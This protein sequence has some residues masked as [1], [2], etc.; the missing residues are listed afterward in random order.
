MSDLLR[1]L[2]GT[3][4]LVVLFALLGVAASLAPSVAAWDTN[5]SAGWE[6]LYIGG[7]VELDPPNE[8]SY[9]SVLAARQLGIEHLLG[10]TG[11]AVIKVVDLNATLFRPSLRGM[12]RPGDDPKTPL[13]ERNVPT[14]TH[15]AGLPDYS[16][17][18]YDWINKNSICPVLPA[19][20]TN[21]E[22]CHVFAGWMGAFN[23]NHFGSQS[24]AMYQRYHAIALGLARRAARV[25]QAVAASGVAEELASHDSALR[26]MEIE[27]L[28]F[29]NIG[30]H[31]LQ[32]RWAVGHMW[33][34]W[35]GADFSQMSRSF[36]MNFLVG[37]L[38]GLVHGSESVT[39]PYATL[40]DTIVGPSTALHLLAQDPLSSPAKRPD[41]FK[42]QGIEPARWTDAVGAADPQRGVGDWRLGD[43]LSGSYAGFPLDVQAQ[44]TRMLDCVAAGM[45]DVI[46]AFGPGPSGAGFGQH[47]FTLPAR[48]PALGEH[49][50]DAWA[51]DDAIEKALFSDDWVRWATTEIADD[52]KLA[53]AVNMAPDFTVMDLDI[54]FQEVYRAYRT[55]VAIIGA[56][57]RIQQLKNARNP[58]GYRSTVLARGGLGTLVL[59]KGLQPGN[60][61]GVAAWVE[62]VDL[63]TLPE[64]DARTGADRRA[65]FGFF[66]RSH[67]DHWARSA[68]SI[69]PSIRGASDPT[70]RAACVYLAGMMYQGT[71]SGYDGAQR[72]YRATPS[73]RE[74]RSL[75]TIMG[76]DEEID[77]DDVP[78]VVEPGY[79]GGNERGAQ[80]PFALRDGVPQTIHNWCDA[81]PLLHL[82]RESSG[83][84]N[85]EDLVAL[86]TAG[87]EITLT[88][89][90]LGKD[91]GQLLLRG[92][93]AEEVVARVSRWSDRELR[94][95]LPESELQPGDY[96]VRVRSAD[97]R[98]SVGRFVLRLIDRQAATRLASWDAAAIAAESSAVCRLERD[99]RLQ[100]SVDEAT[101]RS[102]LEQKERE[103]GWRRGWMS[104]AD[105][106]VKTARDSLDRLT[107]LRARLQRRIEVTTQAF[108]DA[109]TRFRRREQRL[110]GR[111]EQKKQVVAYLERD[112][113]ARAVR[114]RDVAARELVEMEAE[115][116]RRRAQ[117]E[118]EGED[119]A[120]A[121]GVMRQSLKENRQQLEE[122]RWEIER[123]KTELGFALDARRRLDDDIADRQ[124]AIDRYKE[125][126]PAFLRRVPPPWV[127]RID[128]GKYRAAWVTE[129]AELERYD[130]AIELT[131]RLIRDQRHLIRG[132]EWDIGRAEQALLDSDQRWQYLW[133]RYEGRIQ[134]EAY[135]NIGLELADSYENI[136][137]AKSP[138]AAA[139]ANPL[140]LAGSVVVEAAFRIAD[141]RWGEPPSFDDPKLGREMLERRQAAAGNPAAEAAAYYR[142]SPTAHLWT[143]STQPAASTTEL[144]VRAYPS[145]G[146]RVAGELSKPRE[147][148]KSQLQ[149]AIEVWSESPI[150]SELQRG[151]YWARV[152]LG[153]RG[154]RDA[155]PAD[156]PMR[157]AAS[158]LYASAG[159]QRE[160]AGSSLRRMFS[161]DVIKSELRRL[162]AQGFVS[163]GKDVGKTAFK[164]SIK[165][166]IQEE[167]LD[168][169][170][171]V[172]AEE[173]AYFAF[174]REYA[175]LAA[176]RQREL[177]DL[178]LLGEIR[179]ELVAKRD[180]VLPGRL[181]RMASNDIFAAGRHE[182][183][184][185]FS[186]P[187]ENVQ[188][189]IESATVD[190]VAMSAD[191]KIARVPFTFAFDA[192]PPATQATV[193]IA[194][195]APR[196]GKVLDGDPHSI[197]CYHADQGWRRYEQV[198]DVTHRLRIAPLA[199]GLSL[200]LLI[201]ASG[202]MDDRLPSGVQRLAAVKSTM[203]RWF[204][205]RPLPDKSE[206]AVWAISGGSPTMLVPFTRD[207]AAVLAAIDGLSPSGNTP[208]AQ[209]VDEAGLY[210]L[211]YGSNKRRALIILSDGEDSNGGDYTRSIERLRKRAVAVREEGWQ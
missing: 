48:L 202:S 43:M 148:F 63:T 13:E 144:D 176:Q 81:L 191:G 94:L 120:F 10:N 117:T 8:H 58:T 38:S 205:S 140:A 68:D 91:Q 194:A 149:S 107:G 154:I 151:G 40:G 57:V 199:D 97:G 98:E 180:R 36:G 147:H 114:L 22:V 17:T 85:G 102:E 201:D 35:N 73:R 77:R 59:D 34:R 41:P 119:D 16:Y 47:G 175:F 113:D 66:S 141:A 103:L 49:C 65:L 23:A 170:L 173:L 159:Y 90:R 136:F 29:E 27:A 67:I 45:A 207:T 138:R 169:F 137:G 33:E 125:A 153:A 177:L 171:D 132:I 190:S 75:A 62:P 32:D 206:L 86:A 185:E 187:V 30:L 131:D 44:R 104:G 142:L 195:T 37:A 52:W 116:A 127:T 87:D 31:F 96:R 124:A 20:A 18:M 3:H 163:L 197:A 157:Q 182:M 60:A 11:S 106:R 89:L 112:T 179:A 28:A 12:A 80:Q 122:L 14:P 209:T 183:T 46:Q 108:A 168:A 93:E 150:R 121:R 105:A 1:A 100:Q 139:R 92:R 126:A 128:A 162:S 167:K 39:R 133:H 78:I 181:L 19:R 189:A 76:V 135:A 15:F 101:Y 204:V 186:E 200:V 54:P 196:T 111:I 192:T 178:G 109:D 51:T 50:W 211:A 184:V 172:F 72:E 145:F 21:R 53:D 203:R 69:F 164:E 166:M 129:E 174:R 74:L 95:R 79:V 24:A 84:M 2:R 123:A 71:S 4:R 193:S 152:V 208:L 161:A 118:G 143:G 130:R 61:Y 83:V 64:L 188:V 155:I 210:L 165:G 88:G 99:H 42:P 160:L 115:L 110:V 82:R 70:K 156:D 158:L 198:H 6:S 26:E 9:I 146:S 5:D 56:R 55:N 134:L 7:S 25:R